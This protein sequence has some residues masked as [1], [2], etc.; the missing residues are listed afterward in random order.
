M[1]SRPWKHK[2][3]KESQEPLISIPESILRLK[4]HPYVSLG[5]PYLNG[6]N[7]W[8]LRKSVVD[9]LI[10]AQQFLSEINSNL[11]LAVFDALRPI[12]VQKFMFEFTIQDTC[13]SRGIDIEDYSSRDIIKEIIDEVSLFWAE[14]SFA[15][16]TPPPHSTGAAIDF[17]LADMNGFLI[18]K[19]L[20]MIVMLIHILIGM[21][22]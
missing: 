4:P 5:A 3:I 20:M 7:P 2:R 22:T 13:K 8:F 17:T 10:N 6:L 14:P 15:P 21:Q 16:T 12:S 18:Q 9:R 1:R 11:Q 19:I